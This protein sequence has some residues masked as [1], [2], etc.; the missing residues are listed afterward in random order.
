MTLCTEPYQRTDDVH[1]F[2]SFPF[3]RYDLDTVENTKRLP[4]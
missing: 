2:T 1:L 4:G 3:S